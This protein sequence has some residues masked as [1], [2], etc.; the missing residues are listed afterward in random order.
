[1]L[2]SC[3]TAQHIRCILP[4]WQVWCSEDSVPLASPSLTSALLRRHFAPRGPFSR[5]QPDVSAARSPL[6]TSARTSVGVQI[7]TVRCYRIRRGSLRNRRWRP[8]TRGIA[9]L[10]KGRRPST[11][12]PNMTSS[13]PSPARLKTVRTQA[14]PFLLRMQP[15]EPFGVGGGI[16]RPRRRQRQRLIPR[17]RRPRRLP[18]DACT[19]G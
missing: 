9:L 18:R 2:Q 6:Q 14:H 3:H 11:M 7:A 16:H 13:K 10:Y 15:V 17:P 4:A 8:F 5:T 12:H 1:M 19:A